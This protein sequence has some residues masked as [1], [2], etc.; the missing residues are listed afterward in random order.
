MF[1]VIKK[2]NKFGYPEQSEK[3]AEFETLEE[4][5]AYAKSLNQPCFFGL[6]A[7]CGYYVSYIIREIKQ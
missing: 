5:K 1:E 2:F 6:N 7:N 4:A 3:V